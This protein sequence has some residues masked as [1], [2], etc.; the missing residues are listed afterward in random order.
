MGNAFKKK[1]KSKFSGSVCVE[2]LH[3]KL[4]RL[5]VSGRYHRH[6][7]QV[8]D[9]YKLSDEVLGGGLSGKVHMA[10]SK[11]AH[12]QKFAVKTLTTRSMC[13]EHKNNIQ[14]EVEVFLSMDHPH[15]A[16]LFDV[17]ESEGSLALVMECLEG[18]EL[19][20]RAI[21]LE[22]FSERDAAHAVY[23][24]L[25]ALNYI[26]SH[27]MVHRDI[28]L[29]NWL[30]DTVGGNH[31][32]L[33]DF[34]FS[35]VWAHNT[36]MKANCGTLSYIAPEVLNQSYT[37]QCDMWSLGVCAF[38]LLAGYMPFSGPDD[39]QTLNILKGK[40]ELEPD[41]WNN[42]SF[43][44]KCFVQGLLQVDPIARM[45]AQSALQHEWIQTR[46][47]P[48]A[49]SNVDANIVNALRAFSRASKFRRCCMEML[50][51][52]LSNDERAQVRQY[53]IDMDQNKQGTITL[54]DLRSVLI[55]NFHISD[56]ETKQ[57]FLAMDTNHDERIHYSDFLA[58]MVN[59]RIALHDD[60]LHMAFQKFDADNSGYITLSD[61]REVLGDHFDGETVEK[62][63][64]EADQLHDGRI[65]YAEF[66]SYL[67]GDPLPI[68]A[69]ATAHIIDKQLVGKGPILSNSTQGKLYSLER[70]FS[71]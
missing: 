51:W 60:M 64:E 53:F 25:L 52:S 10:T 33:I 16:R 61:L 49:W 58:A 8:H 55:D 65:S 32:K 22:G 67:R 21:E 48:A 41:S 69:E 34:G 15:V 18:G 45:T 30:Y 4:G 57:I 62:L 35:K 71:R 44:A 28:K 31:L 6:P 24:M 1:Q 14:M 47:S 59:T 20:D 63:L 12:N 5:Q 43:E 7:R 19:L 54:G 70:P 26:H 46:N 27:G 38:I 13:P 11:I 50:A 39:E 36:K 42:I 29:E 2:H 68:H 66:A 56:E 3:D 40:Y 23:Q 9:D 37:N 17:Y